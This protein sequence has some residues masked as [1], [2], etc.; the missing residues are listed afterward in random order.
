MFIDGPTRWTRVAPSAS[1]TSAFLLF[2]ASFS[3]CT[4]VVHGAPGDLD[5]TF[6]VGG[7]VV[8]DLPI[9]GRATSVLVDPDQKIVAAGW[10][11][12]GQSNRFA[13]A[14]Y[15]YHGAPDYSFGTAGLVIVDTAQLAIAHD[16]VLQADGKLI[17][18]GGGPDRL[19]V[20]LNPDGSLDDSFGGA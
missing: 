13:I 8:S 5:P 12:S 17:V 9:S 6:G 1:Q 16:V 20:R 10:T 14:R 11:Q 15:T 7:K 4:D 3:L 18:A 19:L 2:I